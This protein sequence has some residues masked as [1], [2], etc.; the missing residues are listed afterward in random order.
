MRVINVP[1]VTVAVVARVPVIVGRLV[2][3]A[4]VVSTLYVVVVVGVVVDIF[5][6]FVG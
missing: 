2:V 5:V 1:T 6:V 3:V 4:D